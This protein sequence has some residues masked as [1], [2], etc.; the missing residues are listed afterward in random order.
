M[1]DKILPI[2]IAEIPV[3]LDLSG[4]SSSMCDRILSTYAAFVG[5]HAPAGLRVRVEVVAG[6]PFIAPQREW[7]IRTRKRAVWVEYVSFFE[8]GWVD[9]ESGVAH[10]VMRPE[11]H[12]ENFLRVLFAWECVARGGLLIHASGV[13]RNGRGYVFFGRS[14]AGKTTVAHL[15]GSAT[16]LSDDLVVV[17]QHEGQ[18]WVYGVPFQGAMAEAPRTNASA[19]LCGLFALDKALVHRLE[20]MPP[21]HAVAEL[22]ACVPFVMGQPSA[23]TEVMQI[24]AGLAVRVPVRT[25]HFRRDAGFW[26]LLD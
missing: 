20:G 9:R 15:A 8:R 10:L 18:C 19:P 12:L 2:V 6:A 21:A 22:A 26:S 14:G 1:K 25:L 4:V 11:G 23:A 24:C 17:G 16:V 13:I 3:T 7:Q 5:E